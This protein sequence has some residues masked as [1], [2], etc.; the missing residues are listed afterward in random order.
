MSPKL[1]IEL[2]LLDAL[3]ILEIL[4]E[5]LLIAVILP[6]VA[7]SF[8]SLITSGTANNAMSAITSDVAKR[9][10]SATTS[11]VPNKFMSATTSAVP[12]I[13]ISATASAVPSLPISV[14]LPATVVTSVAFGTNRWNVYVWAVV[15]VST[16]NPKPE[17]IVEDT[18]VIITANPLPLPFAIVTVVPLGVKSVD[19]A[20]TETIV[21]VP[22]L[23]SGLEVG[24]LV[25]LAIGTNPPTSSTRSII[26]S[27]I[28]AVVAIVV[29]LSGNVWPSLIVS[30]VEAL[31]YLASAAEVVKNVLSSTLWDACSLLV[32]ITASAILAIVT[33]S[34]FIFSVCTQGLDKCS[35]LM[36]SSTILSASIISLAKCTWSIDPST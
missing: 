14:A 12:S 6:D 11:V 15:V 17:G 1:F 22:L 9:F 19:A 16:K 2:K 32:T 10:I 34:S 3:L 35:F 25:S 30:P 7:K 20:D 5:Q 27:L 21:P 8:I 24:K 33:A 23:T 13:A 29:S 26:L 31:K 18:P 36:A 28:A 4:V